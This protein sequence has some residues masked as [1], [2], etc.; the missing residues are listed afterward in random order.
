MCA[1]GCSTR[2]GRPSRFARTSSSRNERIDRSWK[3]GSLAARLIRYPLWPKTERRES[4][5]G[6]SRKALTSAAPSGFANHCM[7][8][9]TKICIAVQ[10]IAQARSMADAT[11]PAVETCAP[12]SGSS[13]RNPILRLRVAGMMRH[14]VYTVRARN[15]R[16]SSQEKDKMAWQPVEIR[17][18]TRHLCFSGN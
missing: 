16:P 17:P 12:S 14:N 11:P 5:S 1:P 3:A 15:S 18:S 6:C 7:L 13:S 10:P 9:F 4:R 8:F 2:N